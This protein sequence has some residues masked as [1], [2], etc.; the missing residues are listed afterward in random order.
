MAK[1]ETRKQDRS[2]DKKK[3]KKE[4]K[5]KKAKKTSP[6][7]RGKSAK[8]KKTA[9]RKSV[10]Y[11]LGFLIKWGFVAA[12]WGVLL[13]GGYILWLARDLPNILDSV[14]FERKTAIVF[15][16]DNGEEIA[17]YGEMRGNAVT[18]DDL[19]DH[20]VNAVLAIEDRRFYVHSGVDPLGIA[21]AMLTNLREG[22]IVQGGSTISQQLAKNLFLSHDRTFRRKI[23]EA[24]LALWLERH[25]T[26]DEIL[27]AYLNR[28]Y[29]GSG[30]YG[31]DAAA[32]LYF[33]KPATALTLRESATLAGMLKA[34]SRYNPRNNPDLAAARADVVLEAMVDAGFL[35]RADK[36]HNPRYPNVLERQKTAPDENARYFTD[37]TMEQIQDLIGTPDED[38]QVR[39][40]LDP[41]IQ[42]AA[43]RALNETLTQYGAARGVSQGA[44]LVMRPDGAVLAMVGGRSYGRSQFNRATQAHR[45]PG[46]AF[47]PVVY[48]AA[49]LEGAGPL[50]MV[51]DAPI[52][53]G[54]YRPKNFADEYEGDVTLE[55]ALARSLNTAAVRVADRAGIANILHTGR[56]LGI[57]ADLD[58]NLSLALGSSGVPM[59]EMATAYATLAARGRAIRPYAVRNILTAE[60][61]PLYHHPE[62]KTV[63]RVVPADAAEQITMMLRRTVTDGTGRA[64]ALPGIRAAGKTGTSQDSRDAWFIGYTDRFVA[65]VWLGNDDNTP[66][67]GVT[68]GSLP[69][70]IWRETIRAAY[71]SPS[72]PAPGA[73]SGS[74]GS[75]ALPGLLRRL[76]GG[77]DDKNAEKYNP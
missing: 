74:S 23:R 51:L 29:L 76:L 47:K 77:G 70:R 59:L 11:A 16:A 50:D 48:L 17:R 25:L 24:M 21:R 5:A 56:Q 62:H 55:T 38:L 58:R 71:E 22:G 18:I 52:T 42:A 9:D 37:W 12:L 31:V 35:A 19:P 8:K 40:T 28:V 33:S 75:T 36:Q 63:M 46:S 15:R 66:M 32:H 69:A 45:P 26:K 41:N 39:T 54:A 30:A 61:A 73:A 14:A 1:K 4:E 53:E 43:E 64:A 60:G 27:S 72:V 13:I 49:L 20:L 65:A 67:D 68:G 3:R 57:R 34:P 2:K 7:K 6:R 10:R 44:V